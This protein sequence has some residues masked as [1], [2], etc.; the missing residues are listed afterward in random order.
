[1][2]QENAANGNEVNRV[3][4]TRNL[5]H[6]AMDALPPDSQKSMLEFFGYQQ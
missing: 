2:K 6:V 4:N 3:E 5:L 1:M